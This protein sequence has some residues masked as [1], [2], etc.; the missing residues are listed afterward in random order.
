M[1]TTSS[2]ELAERPANGAVVSTNPLRLTTLA[3]EATTLETRLSATEATTA[4]LASRRPVLAH[5]A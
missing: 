1:P 2:S 4:L 5:G 3:A